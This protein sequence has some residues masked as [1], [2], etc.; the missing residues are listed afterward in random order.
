MP[1]KDADVLVGNALRPGPRS[2]QRDGVRH[3]ASSRSASR[4]GVGT[5]S[6]LPARDDRAADRIELRGTPRA[7]V[8][9]RRRGQVAGQGLDDRPLVG[10]VDRD[11]LGRRHRARLV[12]RR[13]ESRRSRARSPRS[14]PTSRPDAAVAAAS[15]ASR[16]PSPRARRAR[17]PPI[18]S[19]SPATRSGA[20]ERSSVST[21][22]TSEAAVILG[23]P[24]LGGRRPPARSVHAS[25]RPIA[26]ATTVAV[27]ARSRLARR[28]FARP[29]R[30]RSGA[31]ARRRPRARRERCDR[32][33]AR[34][35]GP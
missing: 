18:A 4:L 2:D 25:S 8:A 34:G 5:P 12:H 31:A 11:T 1:G 17:R 28:G 3:L 29:A 22:T 15:G 6:L 30:A 26:P 33:R 24:A 32:V 23:A 9:C 27:G 21:E 13:A 20:S 16:A 19:S 35:R 7:C 10:R 14:S